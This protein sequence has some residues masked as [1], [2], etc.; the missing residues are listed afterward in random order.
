MSSCLR[1]EKLDFSN[2]NQSFTPKASR[3]KKKFDS[4]PDS[5]GSV[6]HK[7]KR[8][9]LM[10]SFTPIVKKKGGKCCKTLDFLHV[11]SEN[12]K[13]QC[14]N[15]TLKGMIREAQEKI[16]ELE[17]KLKKANEEVSIKDTLISKLSAFIL[18][19]ENQFVTVLQRETTHLNEIISK[20]Q[21][22]LMAQKQKYS[23][24]HKNKA[25]QIADPIY[26][27][28]LKEKSSEIIRLQNKLEKKSKSFNKEKAILEEQIFLLEQE[29]K[30]A[31]KLLAEQEKKDFD[32][33]MRKM[34][35]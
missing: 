10:N 30:K 29:L 17:K 35:S 11:C 23:V 34:K 16:C 32:S 4:T 22:D 20:N 7:R 28:M 18:D 14:E 26:E 2:I 8:T 9:A 15:F 13:T 5:L 12:T 33:L 27:E 25:V 21:H 6:K 3:L 24:S 19:R 31:E 1:L